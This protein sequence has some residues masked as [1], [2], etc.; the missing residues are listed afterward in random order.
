MFSKILL[1][2]YY[3]TI[4]KIEISGLNRLAGNQKNTNYRLIS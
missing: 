2:L 3:Q 4:T 1:R